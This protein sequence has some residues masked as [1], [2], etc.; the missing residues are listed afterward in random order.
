MRRLWVIVGVILVVTGVLFE[1]RHR[2]RTVI[3]H[4]HPAALTEPDPAG[5]L[6]VVNR[7]NNFSDAVDLWGDP[8]RRSAGPDWSGVSMASG[9][10][11]RPGRF[12]TLQP[13]QEIKADPAITVE[14]KQLDFKLL[15]LG[16]FKLNINMTPNYPNSDAILPSRV[17]PGISGSFSF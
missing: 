8:W 6:E 12:E 13:R 17:D 15:N 4:L 9:I 10:D 2:A 5:V 7:P 3:P 16:G 11:T 1:E 14:N